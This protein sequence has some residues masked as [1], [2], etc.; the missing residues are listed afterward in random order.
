MTRFA[1][2]ACLLLLAACAKGPQTPR[3]AQPLP[4]TAI[5]A[6][7]P[8]GEP[9]GYTGLSAIQVRAA[10]GAPAFLRKDGVTQMWRYDGAACK[11]FFFLYG[12]AGR[13][14]V[15]HVETLPRGARDA[16]DPGCL[17]ALKLSPAKTS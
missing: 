4:Q 11:A 9:Q 12:D 2:L 10:F 1:A 17:T 6:A 14:Q 13:E 7:P 3:L 5:P 15:R 8:R 16:A